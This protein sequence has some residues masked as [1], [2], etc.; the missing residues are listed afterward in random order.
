MENPT[1]R[2]IH[3]AEEVYQFIQD[4]NE[5]RQREIRLEDI[6][7]HISRTNTLNWN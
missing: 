4:Q 7:N 3:S 6:V 5:Q 2:P 1:V